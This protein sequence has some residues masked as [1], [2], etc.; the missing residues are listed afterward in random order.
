MKDGTK[1]MSEHGT[2]ATDPTGEARKG[3]PRW[4]VA[5]KREVVLRILR[6]E[7]LD[8]LSRALGVEIYRL[9][10][11]RDRA[12]TGLETALKERSADDPVEAELH[13]ALQRLGEM[14]MQNELLR[15]R[16]EKIGPFV[17]RRSKR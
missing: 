3:A 14:T 17:S 9:E 11:W 16:V 1:G 4:S 13:Q 15:A 12:L 8:G 5:R 7:S 2:K 6:G 10:R